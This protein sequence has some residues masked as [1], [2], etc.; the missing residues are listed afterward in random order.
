MFLFLIKR[1]N[2]PEYI[3]NNE[4]RTLKQVEEISPTTFLSARIRAAE[5]SCHFSRALSQSFSGLRPGSSNPVCHSGRFAYRP[6]HDTAATHP[7]EACARRRTR[8][9]LIELLHK[10]MQRYRKGKERQSCKVNR[11]VSQC[12][13]SCRGTTAA[14]SRF[15]TFVG[16]ASLQRE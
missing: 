13:K 3:I 9:H 14:T 7:W 16:A 4:D 5:R 11:V 10:H 2:N 1:E 6:R 15:C 12:G 8:R